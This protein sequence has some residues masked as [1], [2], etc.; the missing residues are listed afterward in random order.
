M[1]CCGIDYEVLASGGDFSWSCPSCVLG[2]LPFANTTLTSG[3]HISL[4]DLSGTSESHQITPLDDNNLYHIKISN[5]IA[6]ICDLNVQSMM[7]KIDELR[8]TLS[9]IQRPMIFG[10][11]ETW[12][13]SSITDREISMPSYDLHRR[14]RGSRGGGV[15]LY[16]PER[17]RSRRRP[18]LEAACE[19]SRDS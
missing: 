17:F 8:C 13:N 11:S 7:P 9:S 12:L 14:D 2:E 5:N 15:L 10:L 1:R 6:I 3:T 4:L 18:D 19:C 16:V